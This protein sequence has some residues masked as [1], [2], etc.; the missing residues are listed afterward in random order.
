[1]NLRLGHETEEALRAE[2]RRTRRSQQDIVREAVGKY[3]GVIPGQA[4]D[5]DSL[6]VS[7]KIAPPRVAFRDVRPRLCLEPGES[8]VDLLDRDDRI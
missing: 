5:V 7:G 4:G 6:I 1:M 2:A 3:L 8:S